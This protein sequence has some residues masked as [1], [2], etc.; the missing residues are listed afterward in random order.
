MELLLLIV[1]FSSQYY[2]RR[3]MTFLSRKPL[4]LLVIMFSALNLKVICP[5]VEKVASSLQLY[6]YR[7]NHCN[8]FHSLFNAIASLIRISIT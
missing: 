8:P 4:P 2:S 5:L 3:L 6:F 1:S 7:T